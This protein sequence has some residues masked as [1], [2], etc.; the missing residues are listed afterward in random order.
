MYVYFNIVAASK[1]RWY[2]LVPW[3]LLAPAYWVLHSVAAY[4]AL[5][6]LITNPH[7]WEKTQHGTSSKTREKV[8]EIEAG[9]QS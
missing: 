2:H 3:G 7:Y 9:A 6:Q 8:A 1:R 4:K 5:G